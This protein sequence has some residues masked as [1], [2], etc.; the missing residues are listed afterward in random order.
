MPA[1]V[2]SFFFFLWW[3]IVYSRYRAYDRSS[4]FL[5]GLS[6][7]HLCSH[8]VLDPTILLAIPIL[9][10]RHSFWAPGPPT[11][12]ALNNYYIGRIRSGKATILL[13]TTR[14]DRDCLEVSGYGQLRGKIGIEELPDCT[15]GGAAEVARALETP[16]QPVFHTVLVLTVTFSSR[17][18]T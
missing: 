8:V 13:H 1:L 7:F 14:A 3:I 12:H 18:Y 2:T 11:S 6:G 5:E 15:N 4:D 17:S 9:T 16:C 10:S